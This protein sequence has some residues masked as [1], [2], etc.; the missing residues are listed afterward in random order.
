MTNRVSC[1]TLKAVDRVSNTSSS[2]QVTYI[3]VILESK[4]AQEQIRPI[5]FESGV[6]GY[7]KESAQH[8]GG[9]RRAGP[10]LQFYT[11]E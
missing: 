8:P 6:T 11:A 7:T 5:Q 1:R 2:A 4:L 9:A 10:A 3:W